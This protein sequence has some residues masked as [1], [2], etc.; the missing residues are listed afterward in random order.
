MSA[1]NGVGSGLSGAESVYSE[2]RQGGLIYRRFGPIA[3]GAGVA[4]ALAT[5][6]IFGG[7]TPIIPT[8]GVVL[9]LLLGDLLVVAIVLSLIV[10]ELLRLRASRRASR[11]G[12]RLH[13]RLIA[14][15]S[16]VAATPAFVT[17]VVA[18][19]SVEWA[20]NPAFMRGLGDFVNEA[21]QTAQA[22]REAQ[23]QSLLR[24]AELTAADLSRS[25]QLMTTDPMLFQSFLDQ[26][27]SAF[28]FNV[29][30]IVTPEGK[31][32]TSAASSDSRLIARPQSNDFADSDNRRPFCALLN[33]GGAFI[34]LRPIQGLEHN[35]LYAGRALDQVDEHFAT[36]HVG[37]FGSVQFL[38]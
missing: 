30:A 38:R 24:D 9:A 15:F 2:S 22:Y 11:A 35:Y 34:A 7:F 23:C 10:V 5:F 27:S 37:L 19:V 25:S 21:G 28:G 18:T 31:V 6:V 29:S 17:A 3:V 32:V 8:T 20:I 12:A 36:R 14:L 13:T 4:L 16:L 26:R 33:S 1:N